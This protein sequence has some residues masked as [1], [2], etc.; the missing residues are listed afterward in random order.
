MEKKYSLI[1]GANRGIGFE[2][3][4]QLGEKG[5]TVILTSR[6]PEEGKKAYE[7]LKKNGMAIIYHQLDV[8][9]KKSIDELVSFIKTTI[10]KIDVLVNNA[11]V[12]LDEGIRLMDLPFE[13]FETTFKT[14]FYGPVQLCRAIIPFMEK[15]G[16]K[17]INVSSGA[18]AM[19]SMTA[20]TGAYKISKLALNGFTRILSDETSSELIKINS[21][22][23]G[24]VRTKMGGPSA[25]RSVEEGA[26]TIVWLATQE[27]GPTGKFF[28]DRKEIDW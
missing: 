10:K 8:T 27:S 21:V 11:G 25:S 16:G 23:P 20:R 7:K 1:T 19:D 15:H 28:Q 2:V 4:Q 24:W 26:D 18:G 22:C 13:K 6:N 17:I 3:A 12:Y 14:N 9:D 5:F